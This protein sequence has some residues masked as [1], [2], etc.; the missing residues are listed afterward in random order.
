[1]SYQ[2]LAK[3]GDLRRH[4]RG[5]LGNHGAAAVELGLIAPILIV[6]LLGIV[7]FGTFVNETEAL[8]S[9][10]RIGAQYARDSTT[11]QA[12]IQV[13]STPPVSAACTTG[14]QN[15]MQNSIPFSP[16]LTFPASFTLTCECE[17]TGSPSTYK[18]I[19]CSQSC[20]TNPPAAGYT[21]PNRVFIT[22]SANKASV[23]LFAIPGITIPA[24]LSEATTIRIQ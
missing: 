22:A 13:L 14:I 17:S 16:A 12:G 4:S 23:R 5:L 6:L 19:A 9:A 24:A 11:C 10:T 18:T 7:S 15:A 8:A 3:L 20:F 2:R 1:M 21:G